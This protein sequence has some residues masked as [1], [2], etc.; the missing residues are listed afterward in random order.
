VLLKLIRKLF[1]GLIKPIIFYS[2]FFFK[3][4]KN[5]INFIINRAKFWY[6]HRAVL[7][8]WLLKPTYFYFG[9]EY[10]R[11]SI[12]LRWVARRNLKLKIVFMD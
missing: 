12:M 11:Y 2:T 5:Y 3:K 7:K 9:Y 6:K 1:F 8:G 4:T 10:G